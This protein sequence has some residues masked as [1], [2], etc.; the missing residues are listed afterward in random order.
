MELGTQEENGAMLE[1]GRYQNPPGLC[2][3]V[4]RGEY[5]REKAQLTDLPACGCSCD[6]PAS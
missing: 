1:V 5:L 2:L 4:P 3:V 6:H